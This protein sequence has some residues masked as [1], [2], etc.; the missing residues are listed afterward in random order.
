MQGVD[1]FMMLVYFVEEAFNI[2]FFFPVRLKR[3]AIGVFAFLLVK[4]KQT[5]DNKEFFE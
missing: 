1:L 4:I 2:C 5:I 3:K